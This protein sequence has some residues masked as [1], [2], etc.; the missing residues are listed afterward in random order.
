MTC[1]PPRNVNQEPRS[2][3]VLEHP[4]HSPAVVAG[5]APVVLSFDVEDHHTIEAAVGL[6]VDPGLARQ[7][8]DRMKAATEWILGMLHERNI[9]ATFFVVG[10]IAEQSPSL[11]RSIHDSGHEVG[12]HGWAHRRLHDLGPDGFRAD[13]RISKEVLEQTIGAEVVGYRAPTF[14]VVRQTAWGL[15][16]LAELGFHYDSSIYPVHHDR[17]GIP[18]APTRP[19]LARGE[20]AE[21]LE[22]PPATLRLGRVNIPVGGGGYFRL[23]PFALMSRAL[24]LSRKGPN[25]GGGATM[26]YFH[27][28]EFDPDQPRLPLKRLS[29]FRTYV[30][31][32]RLRSRLSR[33]LTE[34]TFSRAV[35]LARELRSRLHELPRYQIPR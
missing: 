29:R 13:L 11:V 30:G 19:F 20:C 34:Y 21:I 33:L 6:T 3:L 9:R 8:H 18:D 32:N 35:D 23:F 27:P 12:S 25:R 24:S 10:R 28:W 17:Y 26:L 14:S 31:I 1:E 2:A 16:I 4:S 15:D 7:Y 22:I 5:P